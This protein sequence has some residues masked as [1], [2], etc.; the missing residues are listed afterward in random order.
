MRQKKALPEE[1]IQEPL[2]AH[3]L[4]C[5]ITHTS[6][7]A[8]EPDASVHERHELPAVNVLISPTHKRAEGRAPV[9]SSE[10]TSKDAAL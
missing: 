6:A 8:S 9:W 5:T 1:A 10:F 3:I 7:R 4:C 2:K